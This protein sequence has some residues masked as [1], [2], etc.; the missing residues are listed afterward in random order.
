LLTTLP[1]ISSPG[2]KVPNLPVVS[3]HEKVPPIS[4]EC[5]E[6]QIL[7]LNPDDGSYPVPLIQKIPKQTPGTLKRTPG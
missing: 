2:Y 5:T 6:S 4:D 7:E 3:Y 1:R